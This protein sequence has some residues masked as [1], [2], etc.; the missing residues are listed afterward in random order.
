L[1]SPGTSWKTYT[2]AKYGWS[3]R[4]PSGWYVQPYDED[5]AFNIHMQGALF[6]NVDHEFVHP[7]LGPNHLTSRWS[8]KELP[9]DAVMVDV[10]QQEA[11]WRRPANAPDTPLPLSLDDVRW[12]NPVA[13]TRFVLWFAEG[14]NRYILE[15]YIAPGAS[16]RDKSIAR[17]IVASISFGSTPTPSAAPAGTEA[18]ACVESSPVPSPIPDTPAWRDA[19]GLAEGLNLPIEQVFAISKLEPEVSRLRA[20]LDEER[21]PG[22]EALTFSW[23]PCPHL[24]VLVTQ[25]DGSEALDVVRRLGFGDLSYLIV[26]QKIPYS[27]Q[28]LLAAQRTL[29]AKLTDVRLN[30]SNDTDLLAGKVEFWLPNEQEVELARQALADAIAGGQIRL[31][32]SAF[33]IEV[34][35]VS[36]DVGTARGNATPTP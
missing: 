4:Y 2:D 19:Q 22:F 14:P 32:E 33:V 21:L 1:A 6:S 29:D 15:G 18:G 11:D 35:T 36:W 7:D 23:Q 34:G 30:S 12:R 27:Q 13:Q 26:V 8:T 31:P 17:G 5:V 9:P 25:G 28:E 20:A 16:E 10:Q 24:A 3:L